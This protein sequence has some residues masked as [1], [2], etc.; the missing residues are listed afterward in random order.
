MPECPITHQPIQ[1]PVVGPDGH[2]YEKDAIESWLQVHGTSPVT[3]EPM[4]I[5]QLVRNRIL[6]ESGVNYY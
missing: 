6:E 4:R 3:R 1:Y 5:D 2:T